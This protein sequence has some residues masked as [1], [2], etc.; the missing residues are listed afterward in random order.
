MYMIVRL[1]ESE[2][3]SQLELGVVRGV[4]ANSLLEYP[5]HH[6]FPFFALFCGPLRWRQS[7]RSAP[8]PPLGAELDR[9]LTQYPSFPTLSPEIE[10]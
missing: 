2:K 1:W 6:F 5:T 10:C 3:R 4:A 9:K 7:T 8:V